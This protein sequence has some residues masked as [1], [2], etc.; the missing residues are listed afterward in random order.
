VTNPDT[1]RIVQFH[2]IAGPLQIDVL[3]LP[4]P[5]M[6]EVR[7]HGKAIGINRVEA[8]FRDGQ[9]FL[10]PVLPVAVSFPMRSGSIGKSAAGVLVG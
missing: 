8:L 10:Q 6:G 5:A 4:Q 9:Y 3:P 2:E 1:A 7:I